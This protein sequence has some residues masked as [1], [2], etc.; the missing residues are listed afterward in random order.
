MISI[1][2][3]LHILGLDFV[4]GQCPK[5]NREQYLSSIRISINLLLVDRDENVIINLS[6]VF[7][8]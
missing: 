7:N 3:K 5:T 6:K 2:R 8:L 4:L 1:N